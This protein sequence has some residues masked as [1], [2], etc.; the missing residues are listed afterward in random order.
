MYTTHPSVFELHQPETLDEAIRLLA[1][2]GD[3]KAIAGGHSLLPA[4]KLR[5]SA[6]S[7]LVDLGRIA[8]LDGIEQEDDR[9]TIGALATHA[10]VAASET[11][12]SACP[13][14]AETA[15]LI[16]DRQVRNRGTIGGSVAHADPGADYPTV[17]TALEATIV[18]VGPE[19][20]R[21]IPAREFFTG[22]FDTALGQGDVVTAVRIPVT[23]T[24]TGAAY[25]KHA[26]PA[27]GYAVAGAAAVVA[28]EGGTCS[29]ARLV[30]GGAAGTP[31][32][33]A[34]D[35]LVGHAPSDDAIAGATA[36]VAE[37]LGDLLSDTY[38][39]ADYR[40]HLAGVLARRALAAAADR[41][42]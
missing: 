39:S 29:R 26:H 37:A 20:E 8:G 10:A 24:G 15:G 40:R 17:V 2:N 4:M 21:G 16:G 12:R 23:A 7:T 33:V 42:G 6:P 5:V 13:V 28:L 38:A 25:L 35:G 3:T 34:I 11:V 9:L 1:E 30:I 41:A 32:T 18:V 27:S 36:G 19:G 22:I 14:V 31:V